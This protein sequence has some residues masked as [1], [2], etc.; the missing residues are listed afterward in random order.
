MAGDL[1]QIL[2]LVL[3]TFFTYDLLIM[4]FQMPYSNFYFLE[5]IIRIHI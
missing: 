4:T 1:A 2:G 5:A 3:S